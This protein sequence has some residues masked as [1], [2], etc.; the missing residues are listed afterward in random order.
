MGN[1][2]DIEFGSGFLDM[3]PEAQATKGKKIDKLHFITMK[4]DIIRK[5]K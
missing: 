2:H 4:K 3:T 5:V 1:L